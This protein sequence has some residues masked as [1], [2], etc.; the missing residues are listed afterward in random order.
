M[1]HLSHAKGPRRSAG[2][3]MN[4]RIGFHTFRA[5]GITAYL[6]AGARWRTLRPWP[7]M[8]ARTRQSSTIDLTMRSR[9]MRSSKLLFEDGQHPPTG[10][11]Q[12]VPYLVTGGLR[13]SGEINPRHHQI[14]R[15]TSFRF[16]LT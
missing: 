7:P 15:R 6:E 1:L 13:S 9:S 2:P 8:K 10:A 11:G 5:T 3:G 16:R 12:R 14:H 4:V